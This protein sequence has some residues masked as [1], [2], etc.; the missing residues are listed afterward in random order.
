MIGP[1]ARK[2]DHIKEKLEMAEDDGSGFTEGKAQS[3]GQV[4]GR[5]EKLQESG[6]KQSEDTLDIEGTGKMNHPEKSIA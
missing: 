5:M 1:E 2:V 3:D 6:G 4:D